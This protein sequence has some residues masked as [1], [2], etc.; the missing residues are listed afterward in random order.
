MQV[1]QVVKYLPWPA[2]VP[3]AR[4]TDM[5]MQ[6]IGLTSR[7]NLRAQLPLDTLPF[8]PDAVSTYSPKLTVDDSHS[9]H[10]ASYALSEHQ[11]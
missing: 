1:V 8:V 7:H 4:K 5:N 6:F 3:F 2:P 9:I 11:P 10:E